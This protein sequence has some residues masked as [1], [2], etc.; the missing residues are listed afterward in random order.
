MVKLLSFSTKAVQWQKAARNSITPGAVVLACTHVHVLSH[1]LSYMYH[2]VL[3]VSYSREGVIKG[4]ALPDGGS[5]CKD[6]FTL[7][8]NCCIA[9]ILTISTKAQKPCRAHLVCIRSGD[10][11]NL[12]SSPCSWIIFLQFSCSHCT[13][14]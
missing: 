3:H 9:G 5:G 8:P 13:Y 12:S 1:S 14:S 2:F 6:I 7:H 4:T 10:K 11:H